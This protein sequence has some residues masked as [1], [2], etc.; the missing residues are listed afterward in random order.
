MVSQCPVR[1]FAVRES[2]G[3]KVLFHFGQGKS[4]KLAMISGKIAF[5]C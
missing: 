3:E 5:S 1:V 2:Q 4:G